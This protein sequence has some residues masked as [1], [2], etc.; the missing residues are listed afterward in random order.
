MTKAAQTEGG[1]LCGAVRYRVTRLI[2]EVVHCHCEL[3]RR[4]C[5]GTLMTWFTLPEA[6]L[7]ITKGRLKIFRS[8]E[9]GARGFCGNCGT[10]ITFTSSHYPG[11]VD[12]TV[13]TLDHPEAVTPDHEIWASARLPWLHLA[14]DLPSMPEGSDS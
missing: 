14:G 11:E 8:S 7:A 10:Q 9:H 4:S 13:T 2:E 12:V 5:G 3:C 1:C 6:D